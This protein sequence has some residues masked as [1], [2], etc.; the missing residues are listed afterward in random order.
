MRGT[1]V[2]QLFEQQTLGFSSGHD[3]GVV[4]SSL[5]S[6]SVIRVESASE[7]VPLP[8]PSSRPSPHSCAYA[9]S[10]FLSLSNKQNV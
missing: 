8:P 9:V 1:W 10:L 7:F 4:K 6:G 2:A 5:T 3:L